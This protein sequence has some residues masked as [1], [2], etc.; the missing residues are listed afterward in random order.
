MKKP[1]IKVHI[2]LGWTIVAALA[3]FLFP[4]KDIAQK[5]EFPHLGQVSERTIIAPISFEVPKSEQEFKNE[6]EHAADK[7]DAVFE[8]NEDETG[9]IND[10]LKQYLAK[11]GHYGALQAEIARN[12]GKDSLQNKV[13]QAS[14]LFHTLT[15]RLSTTA[16]Q[17]LSQNSDARDS[18]QKAFVRM[19]ENGVSNTLIANTETSVQLFR[20][21]YNVQDV[22]FIPYSKSEVSFVRNNEEHKVDASRIQP[23]E[24]RIDETFAELQLPFAH[25][26]GI[27][28]AFYEALYVFTLPNVFYLQKETEH[29][30]VVAREQVNVSKGMVPR[31]M[32]I[33]SQ[34]SIVTKDVLEKLEA[35]QIAQQK[36]AGV[37]HFT[38][39]YGQILMF[40]L[41][42]SLFFL[43]FIMFGKGVFQKPRQVWCIVSLAALQL[44]VLWLIHSVSGSI[45]HLNT[46][47]LD[48]LE[49][50]WLYPFT[51][52]PVVAT[53][54]YDRRMGL[55]FATFS[56]VFLGILSGYDLAISVCAFIVCWGAIHGLGRMI[57]YRSQFLWSLII[58]VVA[59]AGVLCVLFLLRNRLEWSV[60]FPTFVGGCINIILCTAIG[61]ALLVHI[62]EKIFG[63]TTDLTLMELSDFNRPALKRISEF[64]PGTFHHSIQVA[65]LAE[66]V[67]DSIGANALL[68]RVMSLYHDLGKTMRPEFFTENQRQGVNPHKALTPEQSA[69]IL[70]DHVEQGKALAKEYKIPEIVAAGI[71][72]HHGDNIIQYF[73]LAAKEKYPD[74]EINPDDYRYK[75]PRPQTREAVILM[76][77]DSIEATSR[78]MA[79]ASQD[80]L[81]AMVHTTIAARLAEGQFSDSDLTVKDLDRLENAFLQSMIGA[82]HTRVKYPTAALAAGMKKTGNI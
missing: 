5:A 62:A 3:A 33:V 39:S 41:L 36:E 32:E 66:K 11:L 79:D 37:K 24:R 23:R 58:S 71:A 57:R 77:A 34:G 50:I 47:S 9:R 1:S 65:N 35:L 61:S 31:G 16:V 51:L 14:M 42:V 19:I 72:E 22:K 78:A 52:T 53:A 70:I 73:Y 80:K 12:G 54:L 38:A 74:K 81:A 4:D 48:G 76:L 2:V 25:N 13:Q 43:Y 26:Q 8:Y 44:L 64:A 56:S 21:T 49:T 18:L 45:Q 7:V 60:F 67:A 30:Q 82:Y 6:K 75:G 68:V 17:Q 29:R 15:K 59:F 63:I 20:D 10:D 40:V 28:S 27:Q 69:K 46:I 55:A